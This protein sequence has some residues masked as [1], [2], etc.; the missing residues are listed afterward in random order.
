MAT[1]HYALSNVFSTPTREVTE[2]Y[3]PRLS[4]LN[5]CQQIDREEADNEG[6]SNDVTEIKGVSLPKTE[7]QPLP[8]DTT[9]ENDTVL[10]KDMDIWDLKKYGVG[11]IKDGKISARDNCDKDDDGWHVYGDLLMKE[12]L[13]LPT[14]MSPKTDH[15]SRIA[16]H[17]DTGSDRSSINSA[18]V[19]KGDRKTNSRIN[20]TNMLRT[21]S[22][23]IGRNMLCRECHMIY[24]SSY[25]KEKK[26]KKHIQKSNGRSLFQTNPQ[27]QLDMSGNSTMSR[28]NVG[29]SGGKAQY[30]RVDSSHDLSIGAV[31]LPSHSLPEYKLRS[32]M[33][34]G[35]KVRTSS[36]LLLEPEAENPRKNTSNSTQ[37]VVRFKL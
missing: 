36:S 10:T 12:L 25:V 21:L 37:R 1:V 4:Y 6:T 2:Q 28:K 33:K 17:V 13:H 5:F 26:P 16:D 30:G 27:K 11:K 29:K 31:R 3:S 15:V 32:S 8:A 34:L 22:E 19:T 20:D 24:D 23:G 14:A 18:K 35:N 7:I 9:V